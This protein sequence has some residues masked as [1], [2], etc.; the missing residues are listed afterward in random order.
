MRRGNIKVSGA[1]NASVFFADNAGASFV[2]ENMRVS[3]TS[4]NGAFFV[5]NVPPG[6][7]GCRSMSLENVEFIGNTRFVGTCPIV[8]WINVTKNGQPMP[9]PW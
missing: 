3:G 9:R 1:M 6:D 8:K 2:M 4:A 5:A 7:I